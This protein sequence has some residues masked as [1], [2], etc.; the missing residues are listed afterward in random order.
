MLREPRASRHTA[1]VGIPTREAKASII[2]DLLWSRPARCAGLKDHAANPRNQ[3]AINQ[4]GTLHEA[5]FVT[6]L[7]PEPSRD[8]GQQMRPSAPTQLSQSTSTVVVPLS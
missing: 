1:R 5:R 3:E 2:D 8:G 4:I 6:A 7:H